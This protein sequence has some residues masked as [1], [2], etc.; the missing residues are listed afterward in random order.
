[1]HRQG[2][3][4]ERTAVVVVIPPHVRQR[5]RAS[6][7]R[8]AER[9]LYTKG[10]MTVRHAKSLTRLQLQPRRTDGSKCHD[11]SP[12]HQPGGALE[13]KWRGSAYPSNKSRQGET[14]RQVG[15][16]PS[17]EVLDRTIDQ[18]GSAESD[19]RSSSDL[20]FSPRT[21]LVTRRRENYEFT[22]N[23]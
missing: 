1:M 15:V 4:Y 13:T 17:E 12:A 19:R 16:R 18:H 2:D 6:F 23:A 22:K 11:V 10:I 9:R 8:K 5:V 21:G 20:R 7:R 14:Q 3:Q